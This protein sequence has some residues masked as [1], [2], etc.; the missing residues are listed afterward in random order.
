MLAVLAAGLLGLLVSVTYGLT[1]E[2]DFVASTVGPIN[3]LIVLASAGI[4]LLLLLGARGQVGS[5]RSSTAGLAI[6]VLV[7]FAGSAVVSAL[8]GGADHDRRAATVARAC[9]AQD[10][11][12]LTGVTFPGPR[13]GPLGDASGGCVLRLS[14]QVDPISAVDDVTAALTRD[15]WR[16]TEGGDQAP[17]FERHGA[18][19]T[20]TAESDGKA[21][22]VVMTLR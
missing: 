2:Y 3:G 4:A 10:R 18:V 13:L 19:M 14:P 9:S 15:G 21:T 20:V 7:V 11:A 8:L 5:H 12:L 1:S 17:T 22:E 16:R 6:A